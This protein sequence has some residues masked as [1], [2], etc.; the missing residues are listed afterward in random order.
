MDK[1]EVLQRIESSRVIPVIRADSKQKAADIAEALIEGGMNCLEITMTV[2]GAVELLSE[3]NQKYQQSVVVG[4]GTVLDHVAANSCIAAGAKFIVTPYLNL[5]VIKACRQVGILICAGALTPTE[6]FTA[7]HAGA[8]VVKV[9][10]ISAVGG[11]EYVKALKAPFPDIKLLATGGVSI[12][13]FG[14]Y[15]DAGAIAVGV[16]GELSNWNLLKEKGKSEIIDLA[17]RFRG[18]RRKEG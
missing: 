16:G 12:H 1:R 15:L 13:N 10:P 6:I 17:M 5:E 4:A 14:E 8:D 2:P 9:F 3:L 7:W 11:A 18:H